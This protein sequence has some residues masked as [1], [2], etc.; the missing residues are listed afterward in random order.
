MMLEIAQTVQEFLH[1]HDGPQVSVF[2]FLIF[3]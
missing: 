2:N 3:I 1:R